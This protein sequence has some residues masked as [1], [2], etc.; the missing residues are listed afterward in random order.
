MENK[1]QVLN[2]PPPDKEEGS[3]WHPPRPGWLKVNVDAA[4]PINSNW[5]AVAALARDNIGTKKGVVSLL[6]ESK[7]AGS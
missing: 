1:F 7:P 5:I 2:P 4:C 3:L 6:E